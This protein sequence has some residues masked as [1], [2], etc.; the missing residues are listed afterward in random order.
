MTTQ[1]DR[2]HDRRRYQ[3]G[4]RCADCCAAN[5]AYARQN[6]RDRQRR[7]RAVPAAESAPKSPKSAPPEAAAPGAVTAAVAAQLADLDAARHRPG[8]AAAAIRLAE[9]LD[10]PEAMPQHPA[11]AGR[12]VELLE[13]LTRGNAKRGRLTVVRTMTEPK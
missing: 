6:K 3:S 10:R 2:P 8:L 7:L 11:A 12:L 9:L 1:D 4:C 5:R 13:K